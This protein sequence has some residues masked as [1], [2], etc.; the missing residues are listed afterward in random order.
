MNPAS[1]TSTSEDSPAYIDYVE[2]QEGLIVE[3]RELYEKL[4]GEVQIFRNSQN[5]S[6]K[7]QANE[8]QM[9]I[10]ALEQY[11]DR[12]A[13]NYIPIHNDTE[14]QSNNSG[15]SS[16]VIAHIKHMDYTEQLNRLGKEIVVEQKTFLH[17]KKQLSTLQL[18]LAHELLASINGI[19]ITNA[20]EFAYEF[21]QYDLR[22]IA[23]V[24]NLR[25]QLMEVD[26]AYYEY[27]IFDEKFVRPY[28]SE[29]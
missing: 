10:C 23:A 6:D 27:H 25:T 28:E 12:Y 1:A 9:K 14:R 8:T 4:N 11:M 13:S 19:S 17:L 16:E 22:M 24:D 2:E 3:L 21:A 18:E 26:A 29:V 20:F 5:N 15:L 7:E